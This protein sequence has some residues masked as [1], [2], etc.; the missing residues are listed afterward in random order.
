[1]K[2]Q[3]TPSALIAELEENAPTI[4]ARVIANVTDKKGESKLKKCVMNLTTGDVYAKKR[5]AASETCNF[6]LVRYYRNYQDQT[7]R[8]IIHYAYQNAQMHENGIVLTTWVFADHVNEPGTAAIN[9]SWDTPNIENAPR[10]AKVDPDATYNIRLSKPRI[11]AMVLVTPEKEVL[12]W[13]DVP[14][15]GYISKHHTTP[16][17]YLSRALVLALHKA[18][19]TRRIPNLTECFKKQ[20]DIGYLGAN[21]Y[22]VFDSFKDVSP[23][24][25]A[26]PLTAT[27]C[28]QQDLVNS[29]NEIKLPDH[30]RNLLTEKTVCF[31]DRLNDEWV[32]LRWHIKTQPGLFVEISRMY[33]NKTDAIQARSDLKGSWVYCRAKL[34]AETFMADRVVTQSDDVFDGTK[35]EYFKNISTELANQS[36]AL[37]ML[38]LYPEFEKMYKSGLGWLCEEYLESP[39]STSWKSFLDMHCGAIDWKAKNIHKFLGLN[40]HQVAEIQKWRENFLKQK[41]QYWEQYY[42]RSIIRTMKNVFASEAINSVDNVTFDYIL[43][44]INVARLSGSYTGALA[45][46]YDMYGADAIHF[47]KD[48]NAISDGSQTL[49]AN[50]NVPR[51]MRRYYMTVD[52]LFGDVFRMIQSGNYMDVLRPRFSSLEELENI[53]AVMTDLINADQAAHEARKNAQYEANFASQKPRW[54]KWEWEGNEQFCVIAPSKPVDI[55]QEGMTLRHCVRSYIPS[56][57]AGETNIMFIREKGKENVPFFTVEVDRRNNIRQVHGMCNSNVCSVAGLT[58]FVTKWAKMKKLK[59]SEVYANGL[60]VVEQY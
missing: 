24:M 4:Y 29:L 30:T 59:Y 9:F 52:T 58:E 49:A 27:K 6:R 31:A 17:A 51:Y 22:V 55:A 10:G 23:F 56:V 12:S 15:Y 36:A 35:L 43:N 1:M 41:L 32:V 5:I 14:K 47:I 39:Y 26:K 44:T 48:L 37:Y 8:D 40:H 11:A 13:D 7:D 45:R 33:V 57:S 20:F 34:K 53:H 2:E 19:D 54:D 60:R 3:I 46:V 38:T 42:A 16:D 50:E 18:T 21:K 28:A 25:R